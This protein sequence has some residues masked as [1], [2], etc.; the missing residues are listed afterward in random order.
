MYRDVKAM[1]QINGVGSVQFNLAMR[2]KQGDGLSPLFFMI[3]IGRMLGKARTKSFIIVIE[4]K[5]LHPCMYWID[6]AWR[7][8]ENRNK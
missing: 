3:T 5:D 1:I 6:L 8:M 7:S 2:I 4:Y